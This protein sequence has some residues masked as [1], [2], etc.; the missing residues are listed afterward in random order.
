MMVQTD[1]HSHSQLL[2]GGGGGGGGGGW[3]VCKTLTAVSNGPCLP[4]T[5]LWEMESKAINA[6]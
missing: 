2:G 3:W 5:G 1:R 6:L 4:M